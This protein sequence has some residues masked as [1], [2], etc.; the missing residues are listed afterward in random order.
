[1]NTETFFL[2]HKF[3][4]N[5]EAIFITSYFTTAT[6]FAVAILICDFANLM[7]STYL[8]AIKTPSTFSI[9]ADTETLIADHS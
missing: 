7:T 2:K 6:T 3:A 8:S 5:L 9:L 1:M 4:M